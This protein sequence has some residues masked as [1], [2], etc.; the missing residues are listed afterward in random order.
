MTSWSRP[1]CLDRIDRERRTRA[2]DL[3][4][5]QLE[6]RV[7][8]DRE[9]DHR[10][11][12]LDGGHLARRL[13]RRLARRH[14]QHPRE[15]EGLARLLGDHEMPDVDRVERAAHQPDRPCARGPSPARAPGLGLPVELDRADDHRVAGLD[16]RA[17]ERGIGAEALEVALEPL[18]QFLDVEVGLRRDPLDL[19]ADD[20]VARSRIPGAR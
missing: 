10:D 17:P 7:V 19:P 18:R 11:A 20:A 13:V 5:A 15:R 14:E 16:A 9:L 2:I 8:G 4:P 3:D 12:M 1:S 6:R